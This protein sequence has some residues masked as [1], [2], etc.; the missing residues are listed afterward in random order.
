[1]KGLLWAVPISLGLWGLV[2]WL[3]IHLYRMLF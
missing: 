3:G 2:I 1:M